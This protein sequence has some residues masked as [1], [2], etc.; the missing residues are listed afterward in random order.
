MLYDPTPEFGGLDKTWMVRWSSSGTKDRRLSSPSIWLEYFEGVPQFAQG[1]TED[2]QVTARRSVRFESLDSPLHHVDEVIAPEDWAGVIRR[3]RP[4]L[5][6]LPEGFRGNRVWLSR[7][8]VHVE[9]LSIGNH[10]RVAAKKINL[11]CAADRLVG[12][13]STR[14]LRIDSWAADRP[15]RRIVLF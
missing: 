9:S 11:S 10:Q 14:G 2:L 1:P 15:L 12:C 5:L 7:R 8:L 4:P 6:V 13:G 3:H